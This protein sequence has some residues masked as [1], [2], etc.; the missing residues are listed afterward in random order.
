MDFL[1]YDLFNTGISIAELLLTIVGLFGGGMVAGRT[2]GIARMRVEDRRRL[3]DELIPKLQRSQFPGGSD[4]YLDEAQLADWLASH[5]QVE[6]LI[7]IMPWPERNGWNYASQVSPV[8]LIRDGLAK[9][10]AARL[11]GGDGNAPCGELR[12]SWYADYFPIYQPSESEWGQRL[13]GL[14]THLERRLRPGRLRRLVDY[15]YRIVIFLKRK[16]G[17]PGS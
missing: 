11:G 14:Q 12:E 7:E 8:E 2:M 9:V 5:E 6:R 17:R 10:R 15:W 3:R 16:L 1:S 4:E 13:S